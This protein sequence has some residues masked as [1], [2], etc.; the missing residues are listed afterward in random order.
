MEAQTES[1][2]GG[3][4]TS[5]GKSGLLWQF[6]GTYL[7]VGLWV[8]ALF[9]KEIVG[10]GK[11]RGPAVEHHLSLTNMSLP[12]GYIWGSVPSPLKHRGLQAVIPD[13][14][15]W[16]PVLGKHCLK[17]LNTLEVLLSPEHFAPQNKTILALRS[18]PRIRTFLADHR[19]AWAWWSLPGP[20]MPHWHWLRLSGDWLPCFPVSLALLL[21]TK[22]LLSQSW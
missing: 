19:L 21:L 10:E 4:G 16:K 8:I 17:W 13:V 15:P 9:W 6:W 2:P 3:C 11:K 22:E 5:L 7:S 14:R 18:S 20:T 1:L 12:P